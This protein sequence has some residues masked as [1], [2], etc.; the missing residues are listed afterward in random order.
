MVALEEVDGNAELLQSTH[1][2][3]EIKP[4]AHIPPVAVEQIAR[5]DEEIDQFVA[6]ELDQIVECGPCRMAHLLGRKPLV[7]SKPRQRAVEVDVGGMEETEI[8][9]LFPPSPFSATLPTLVR[10]EKR[11]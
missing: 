2:A 1:G 4:C 8:A 10:G 3:S 9:H 5:D 7:A 6:G 11:R